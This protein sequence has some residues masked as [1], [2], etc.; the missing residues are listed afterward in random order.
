M[1]GYLNHQTGSDA[2]VVCGSDYEVEKHHIVFRSQ[3]GAMINCPFNRI[4][5]CGTCHRTNS[6]PHMNR[7]LD[8]NYK[9]HLQEKLYELFE[10][11][12]CYTEEEVKTLLQIPKKHSRKLVKSLSI[13]VIGDLV[14]Y[15]KE[16]IIKQAMGGKFYGK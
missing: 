8:I 10:D 4:N 15:R 12:E 2:C 16:D 13:V 7:A 5:L 1:K 9:L 6:G 3:Q 14:G 11:K